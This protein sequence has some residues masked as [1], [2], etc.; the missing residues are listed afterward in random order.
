MSAET[1]G[2]V[3]DGEPRTATST[4]TLLLSSEILQC[5]FTSTEAVWTIRDGEPRTATSTFT[6]LLSSEI[7]IQSIVYLVHNL[8]YSDV[9]NTR[10]T[11][12]TRGCTF[13][14]VD[15]YIPWSSP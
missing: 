9:L 15:I 12:I 7:H 10:Y 13:G 6:Q 4:F 8:M 11:D 5:C 1:V 2:T 14:G 3:R